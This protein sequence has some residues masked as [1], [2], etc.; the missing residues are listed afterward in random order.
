MPE[1]ATGSRLDLGLGFLSLCYGFHVSSASVPP[2]VERLLWDVDLSQV[3]LDRDRMLVLE[4]VMSRGTWE[5]MVWLRGRYP[6]EVL[7][8][9]VREQG[10]RRLSPRDLAYWALICDVDLPSAPGGGRPPW[11][12]S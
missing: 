2:A 9:F 8:D 10:A 7:A 4:R 6:K 11:A 12:G 1:I 5:A 3:D